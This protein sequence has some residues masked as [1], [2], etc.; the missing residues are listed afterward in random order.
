MS[1]DPS[2]PDESDPAW[3]LHR[4][5]KDPRPTAGGFGERFA[6]YL[7]VFIAIV[8]MSGSISAA[9]VLSRD[10]S[11]TAGADRPGSS[12]IDTRP[13]V[14]LVAGVPDR[15][16]D[17][18]DIDFPFPSPSIAAYA[19]ESSFLLVV[20][21]EGAVHADVRSFFETAPIVEEWVET[22][23]DEAEPGARSLGSIMYER[24]G[25]PS[26]SLHFYDPSGGD[27]LRFQE[28]FGV[29]GPW[30]EVRFDGL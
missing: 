1:W 10:D 13:Q 28:E 16:P 30:V 21:A 5:P 26:V 27:Q 23:A 19:D 14:E 7:A 29:R 22:G 25:S 15:L 17:A 6:P 9:V 8:I 18:L 12:T 20:Y 11:S 24:D 3:V 4:L 2:A